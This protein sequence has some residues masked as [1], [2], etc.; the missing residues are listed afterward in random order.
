[1]SKKLDELTPENLAGGDLYKQLKA[2]IKELHKNIKKH[3][4]DAVHSI[5]V[6]IPVDP[7]IEHDNLW[8]FKSQ[9]TVKCGLNS[10]ATS[11]KAPVKMSADGLYDANTQLELPIK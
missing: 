7:D 1:M 10:T 3:G 4:K 5:H 11:A 6:N 9:T 2:A 8:H